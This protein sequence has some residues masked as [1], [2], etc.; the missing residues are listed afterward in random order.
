MIRRVLHAW[1]DGAAAFAATL[2]EQ[3]PSWGSATFE[4]AGGRAVLW[5][6]GLYVNRALAAGVD[7][8]MTAADFET[9]ERLSDAVGVPS[10]I[11]V[12]PETLASVAELAAA[13]GYVA[14]GVVTALRHDLTGATGRGG[15]GV[16]GVDG[17]I[18]EPADVSTWQAIA[19]AGWGHEQPTARRASDAFAAAAA[20]VD[21]DGFVIARDARDGRPIGCATLSMRDGIATLAGMSTL[22]SERRRGVQAALVHH[23]LRRAREAGCGVATSTTVA[24]GASERNLRRLGFE[25]WFEITTLARSAEAARSPIRRR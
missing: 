18:V 11:E 9:L 10:A 16:G 17:V 3:D 13:R 15:G 20:V 4:L 22:P 19:A 8:A 23:R 2:E 21:G 5:G 14:T 25:P 6:R 24:G 7:R 12:T 1:A